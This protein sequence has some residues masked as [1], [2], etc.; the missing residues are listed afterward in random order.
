MTH[1]MKSSL[2]KTEIVVNDDQFGGI[3]ITVKDGTGTVSNEASHL[4]TPKEFHEFIGI[5]LHV[6]AKKKL[7]K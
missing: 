4:F 7:R 6:Q 3:S 2:S 1:T 5:L